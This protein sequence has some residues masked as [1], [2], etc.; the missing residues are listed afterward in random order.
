M[1]ESKADRFHRLAE[2]RVKA[3]LKQVSL[4]GNLANRQ[5][6]SYSEEQVSEILVALDSGLRRLKQRFDH[7]SSNEWEDF[8]LSNK[9]EQ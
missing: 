6:Y 2:R 5:A 9:F 7:G 3:A 1:E 8:R 4:I